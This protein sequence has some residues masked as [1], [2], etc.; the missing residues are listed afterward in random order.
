MN[1]RNPFDECP[2]YETDNV[3][4]TKVK[5]DDA[6]DL[7]ECYSDPITKGHMNNDNW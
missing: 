2:M 4:F 7:F 1:N 6:E 5:M 3:I